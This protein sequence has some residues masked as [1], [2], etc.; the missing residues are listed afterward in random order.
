MTDVPYLQRR[1]EEL[2]LEDEVKQRPWE[3]SFKHATGTDKEPP[4]VD[5]D[6]SPMELQQNEDEGSGAEEDSDV[7]EYEA[8]EDIDPVMLTEKL[9]EGYYNDAGQTSSGFCAACVDNEVCKTCGHK[10]GLPA[11]YNPMNCVV[12]G[13][14]DEH[15]NGSCQIQDFLLVWEKI[16]HRAT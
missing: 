4:V 12:C 7:E 2:A 14:T 9:L 10:N 11:D 8:P 3:Q 1:V 6:D 16:I 15:E 5:D 13:T